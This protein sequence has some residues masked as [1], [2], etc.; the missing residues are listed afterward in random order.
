M[1]TQPKTVP[2][3][4]KTTFESLNTHS[5]EQWGLHLKTDPTG[6]IVLS[7]VTRNGA[8]KTCVMRV[9]AAHLEEVI[10]ALK[11]FHKSNL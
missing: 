11:E 1:P 4:K 5:G 10:E 3:Q 7:P 6:A 2:Y 9:P 8:S